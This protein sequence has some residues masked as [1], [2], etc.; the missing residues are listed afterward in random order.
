[1][2][3]VRPAEKRKAI[4]IFGAG[5]RLLRRHEKRRR[6]RRKLSFRPFVDPQTNRGVSGEPAAVFSFPLGSGG[7]MGEFS[8]AGVKRR[9]CHNRK[10]KASAAAAAGNGIICCNVELL[11]P[12]SRINRNEKS[13]K[14]NLH[15]KHVSSSRSNPVCVPAFPAFPKYLFR[16]S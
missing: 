16:V 12:P 5:E 14:S 10:T 11:L 3:S 6:R 1:M 4:T 8:R 15:S 7:T 9:A 13:L 2:S